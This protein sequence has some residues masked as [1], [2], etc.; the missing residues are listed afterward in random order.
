MHKLIERNDVESIQSESMPIVDNDELTLVYADESNNNFITTEGNKKSSISVLNII[1][2]ASQKGNL[3]ASLEDYLE[4]ICK[5][6]E[7]NESVKAVEI[8][9]KLNISRAS[10]SEALLK[11]ADK[12]LIIYKGH[13]GVTITP[14]G[15]R[16][17]Q[18]V[19]NKHDTLTAIFEEILGFAHEISESNACKI[20]HIINDDI[21]KRLKHFYEYCKKN[22]KFIVNFKKE[23]EQEQ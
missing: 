23:Y 4:I 5:L 3:S 12:G 7:N 2:Q 15:L 6:S 17:A 19:I 11:L 16:I 9:K 20:E 13:K 1:T 8:A 22:R 14:D 18:D 10:V 21:F